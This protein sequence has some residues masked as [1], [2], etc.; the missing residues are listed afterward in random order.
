MTDL[1]AMESLK[2]EN[3]ILRA[4]LDRLIEKCKFYGLI[5]EWNQPREPNAVD[6][7]TISLSDEDLFQID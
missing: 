1:Q 3:A 6:S 5:D 2:R 4:S 7:G